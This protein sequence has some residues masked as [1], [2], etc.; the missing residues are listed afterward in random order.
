MEQRVTNKV[1]LPVIQLIAVLLEQYT[2]F[3]FIDVY[4][5][6]SFDFAARRAHRKNT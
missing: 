5:K 1:Q 6:L 3:A 2:L 4:I